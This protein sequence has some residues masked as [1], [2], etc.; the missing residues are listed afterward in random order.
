MRALITGA[1]GF[2]GKYLAQYCLSAGDEV[3]A[4]GRP[5]VR[6]DIV[7]SLPGAVFEVLD[8]GDPLQIAQ[9]LQKHNPRVIYHLAAL[10][11]LP[12]VEKQRK[13]AF[14]V[15]VGGTMAM[16]DGA[17]A[18]SNVKVIF[19]SSAQIYSPSATPISE[20]GALLPPSFYGMT[21]QMAER[22]AH[23]YAQNG[24][25]TMIARP[26]NHSGP[27]QRAEFVLPSFAKQ[28]VEVEQ[29]K[30]EAT[31]RVGNLNAIRD[32]LHVR[33]VVAAYR[34]L[35]ISG[36]NGEVYNVS[37]GRGRSIASALDALVSRA[38]VKVTVEVDPQR[39][40]AG[41]AEA[42]I[43]DATKLRNETGWEPKVSFEELLDELLVSARG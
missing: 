16:L 35:A 39:L 38:K 18:I 24:V 6:E 12:E 2:V 4:T 5:E 42:I 37:S 17:R 10:T 33:D 23:F 8:V 7:E 25:F 29:G 3:V 32:F 41:D 1:G 11:F 13:L 31:I 40:R 21:K 9:I 36:R 20:T 43:G 22:I 30:R 27:G 15:N 26:F 19:V 14:D 34:S 28:I